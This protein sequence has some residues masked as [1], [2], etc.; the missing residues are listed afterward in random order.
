MT[1]MFADT[2]FYLALLNGR[3]RHHQIAIELARRERR[4]NVTSEFVLLEVGNALCGVPLGRDRFLALIERVRQLENVTIVPATH[5]LFN[6]G[7]ERYRQRGDKTWSLTDCTSFI[8][9]EQRRIEDALT[10]DRHFEQAGFN[11]LLK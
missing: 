10:A 1:S 3:D 6:E 2:S 9:M 11:A 8:I 7:L 5:G 4:S